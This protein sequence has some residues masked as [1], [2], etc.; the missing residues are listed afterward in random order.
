MM[1]LD[2]FEESARGWFDA[3]SGLAKK[4]TDSHISEDVAVFHN[5]SFEAEKELLDRLRE[6]QKK[7]FDAGFG[8][9]AWPSELGGRDLST[10][11]AER[12]AA[13]ERA[14][15]TPGAHEL[16]TVSLHL[17][18]PTLQLFGT[19]EHRALIPAILSGELLACQLFS[20]PEA[21]SDLANLGARAEYDNGEWVV[22]GQ[23]VWTSGAQFAQWG[24]LLVRTDPNAPKHKGISAF[25][26]PMDLPGID[27]R[28]LRQMSGGTSFNEVY[29]DDVRIPDKYRLGE[30][31]QGWKVG[32]TT[33][34]FERDASVTTDEVGGTWE[35]VRHLAEMTGADKDPV[36]RQKLAQV[37][38]GHRLGELAAFKDEMNRG[39]RAQDAT[40]SLRKLQ[41]VARLTRTSEFARDVLG[42]ALVFDSGTSHTFGWGEH[43]LGAP[44]YRIAGGSD[45][46]QKN[47]IA[48]RIL[49]LPAEP[50]VDKN[51]PWRER[52]EARQ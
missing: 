26:I 48:E 11:H 13:V 22:N 45:Q 43:V 7:K 8:A 25:F 52:T 47:I 4:S 34:G 16:I 30:V 3:E 23:K 32:L 46:I 42:D 44:G 51:R 36:K 17:M 29:F 19:M 37:L 9:I 41:W 12:F 33:L 14:Y 2:E 15:I 38:I 49:G 10:E 1:T 21:G 6:W 18:A 5:L 24:E 27:V 50:R 40:G 31:G 39:S 20:E 28:P 35:Q